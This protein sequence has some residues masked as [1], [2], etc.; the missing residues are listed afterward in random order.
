[1]MVFMTAF[2]TP[3]QQKQ[4][5][6]YMLSESNIYLNGLNYFGVYLIFR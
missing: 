1:M 3:R 2:S 5:H 4:K 6:M